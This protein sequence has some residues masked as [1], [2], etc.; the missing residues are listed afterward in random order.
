MSSNKLT[1]QDIRAQQYFD[2]SALAASAG[3]DASVIQRMLDQ[4]PVPHYQAEL[5]LL[6]LSDEL[7]V[8][9]T[10][11]TVQVILFSEE[12]EEES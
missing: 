10:L 7:G 9:F 3:V 12:D 4:Q 11:D 2:L 8:D 6:A 5:V 1:L